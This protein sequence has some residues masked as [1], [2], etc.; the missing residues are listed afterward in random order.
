MRIEQ[1]TCRGW[2]ALGCVG[3]LVSVTIACEGGAFPTAPSTTSVIEPGSSGPSNLSTSAGGSG[4]FN[5]A[6]SAGGSGAVNVG[7]G[8]GSRGRGGEEDEKDR[9]P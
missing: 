8:D 4:S 3:V 9:E 1:R 5:T 7:R 6:T 2:L